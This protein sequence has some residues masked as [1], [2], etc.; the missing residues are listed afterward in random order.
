MQKTILFIIL[1]TLSFGLLAQGGGGGGGGNQ[2]PDDLND[3]PGNS[4]FTVE[5]DVYDNTGEFVETIT[6]ETTGASLKI[7]CDLDPYPDDYFFVFRLDDG[8][9]CFYDGD[10]ELIDPLPLTVTF[11]DF[12]LS[13]HGDYNLLNWSTLDETDNDYF[14]IEYSFDGQSWMHLAEVEGEGT[15][16]DKTEYEYEHRINGYS[17][18]YYRLKQTDFDG[19]STSLGIRAVQKAYNE[20]VS[21][22]IN[23]QN[24]VI[25]SAINISTIDI[26]DLSGRI[27]FSENYSNSNTESIDLD[28]TKGIYIVSVNDAEGKRTTKKFSIH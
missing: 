2:C 14:T 13:H 20:A 25:S 3:S 4:G 15:T 6:C 11:N 21:I 9:D 28:F 17:I 7:E 22:L 8:T 26:F 12:T 1:L 16:L 18:I 19:T 5:V 24:L 27:V 23:Q 10:G